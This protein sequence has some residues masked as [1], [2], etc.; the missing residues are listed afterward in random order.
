V[1]SARTSKPHSSAITSMA[2]A[3]SPRGKPARFRADRTPGTPTR[4]GRPKNPTPTNLYLHSDGTLSFTAPRMPLT[5]G[6][7][8][9]RFRPGESRALSPASHLSDLSRRRLAH[10]GGRR[11]ALRRSPPDVLT[12]CQRTA[13]SR[14]HRHRPALAADLF[15]STSG[16]DSDFIVKLIDVYPRTRRKTPGSRK[17]ARSPASTRNR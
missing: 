8:R 17:T 9:V 14:S 15:A 1:S 13:R 11:P 10:L 6:L 16:T 7:S 5:Q 12:L 3:T 2:K 4:L